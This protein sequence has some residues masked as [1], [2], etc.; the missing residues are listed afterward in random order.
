VSSLVA[1]EALPRPEMF[2]AFG[3]GHSV[4][5][6][7]VGVA[8]SSAGRG[9]RVATAT[10]VFLLLGRTVKSKAFIDSLQLHSLALNMKNLGYSGFEGSQGSFSSIVEAGDESSMESIHKELD[11]RDIFSYLHFHTKLSKL[12]D[13]VSELPWSLLQFH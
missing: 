11:L 9:G 2:F 3:I 7:G 6:H 8:R 1:S 13:V 10:I 4:Y 5:F 12:C